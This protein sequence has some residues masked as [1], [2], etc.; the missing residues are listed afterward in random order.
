MT[1]TLTAFLHSAP[2]D[3]P[4]FEGVPDKILSC[5]ARRPSWS[6]T[7]DL[8]EHEEHGTCRKL[9]MWCKSG[10][11]DEAGA[12]ENAASMKATKGKWFSAAVIDSTLVRDEAGRLAHTAPNGETVMVRPGAKVQNMKDLEYDFEDGVV[13]VGAV[14]EK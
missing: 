5:M 6:W 1:D 7:S 3:R 14:C 11:G 4:Q 13:F 9:R 12:K 10:L 8:F 2:V